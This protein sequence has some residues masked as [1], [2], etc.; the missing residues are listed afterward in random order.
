MKEEKIF[1]VSADPMEASNQWE[2]FLESYREACE[3]PFSPPRH[4]RVFHGFLKIFGN[5]N[6]LTRFVIRH[7]EVVDE[8]LQKKKFR[9]KPA[10]DWAKSARIYKYR[11]LLRITINDFL[12][13][14]YQDI[15][16]DLSKLALHFLTS[17]NRH[18]CELSAKSGVLPL[19]KDGHICGYH[20]FTLGKLG[21]RELNYS[22]DIDLLFVTQT[23]EGSAGELSLHE[24]FVHRARQLTSLLQSTTDDGFLYRVD[25]DLRPEGASGT[26]VNSLEAMRNYYET[27]G[28]DWER[29]VFI[30]LNTGAGE[31]PVANEFNKLI[32]PFVYRKLLD[33]KS[34]GSIGGMKQ[35]I[36]E[37][38]ILKGTSDFNVKLSPG[39][40]RDIEFFVQAFQLIYGGQHP[41]LQTGNTLQAL[42]ILA[43]LKIINRGAA[44]SLSGDYLFLRKLEH[45]LQLA[46]EAQTHQLPLDESEQLKVARRMGY[47]TP[48]PEKAYETFRHDLNS[49]RLRVISSFA[50]LFAKPNLLSVF[51]PPGDEP[52]VTWLQGLQQRLESEDHFEA[53]LNILRIFKKEKMAV[54]MKMES[55]RL[56][57]RRTI[58]GQI[59]SLAEIICQAALNLSMEILVPQYG[60]ASCG[61]GAAN[62]SLSFLVSIGMGK[63][64]SRELNYFSDLDLI[65][66]YSEQGTSTGPKKISNGEYFARLVQKFMTILSVPTVTGQLYTVDTDLRPSGNAGP[67][68]TSLESFIDYQK[69]SSQ[70]WEKQALTRARPLWGSPVWGGIIK[71]RLDSLLYSQPFPAVIRS[72]MDRLRS[73]VEKEVSHEN[74]S[75]LDIKLGPGGMMDVEFIVQFLQLRLGFRE[76]LMRST[77][78]FEC[79]DVL[80]NQPIFADE[81]EAY[82]LKEAYLFY[83]TLESK[84]SLMLK[85]RAHSLS[86]LD[87]ALPYLASQ[88]E[89]GNPDDLIQQLL[90]YRKKVREIYLKIFRGKLSS[91]LNVM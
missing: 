61:S 1:L 51:P 75:R 76:S 80:A 20:I 16:R 60:Y 4:N 82:L 23:D 31:I 68:V 22:S 48:E 79:L 49:V 17:A 25:W 62:D 52:Y 19:K 5:S 45:R 53:K 37:G 40:I 50:N 27:F 11:E 47:E 33:T 85:R 21:G 43:R 77:G 58:L 74:A 35:K 15:F 67:L 34:I 81:H 78:I 18:L 63:L 91:C 86:R 29:Q 46:E 28:V 57:E 54:V 90:T 30:R 42:R 24:F 55:S 83:R 8:L 72:E 36:H 65:F 13:M 56:N 66:V 84:M 32:R 70:I 6:F 73:R 69:K 39:G 89:F 14:D 87:P 2:R 44:F 3:R 9:S 71:T 10:G 88:L 7:P 41:I 59:S 12:G 26:L 38:L 64:G